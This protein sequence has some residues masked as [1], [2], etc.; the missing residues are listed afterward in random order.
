MK[1]SRDIATAAGFVAFLAAGY[2]LVQ[3]VTVSFAM[4]GNGP[5]KWA[6][7]WHE[8]KCIYLDCEG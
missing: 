7:G 5:I 8:T 3:W 1:L 4:T 2:L 6:E